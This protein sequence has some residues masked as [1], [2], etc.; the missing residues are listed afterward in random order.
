MLHGRRGPRAAAQP[1]RSLPRARVVALP[2]VPARLRLLPRRRGGGHAQR[3]GRHLGRARRV[4]VD[5]GRGLHVPYTI[6]RLRA[7][8]PSMG[9]RYMGCRYRYLLGSIFL[10]VGAWVSLQALRRHSMRGSVHPSRTATQRSVCHA[11]LSS[12]SWRCSSVPRADVEGTAIW[13]GF[14]PRGQRAGERHGTM[15]G[16]GMC[17]TDWP[18]GCPRAVRRARRRCGGAHLDGAPAGARRLDRVRC[19]RSRVVMLVE[20]R[21]PPHLRPLFPRVSSRRRAGRRQRLARVRV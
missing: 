18:A 20:R 19:C 6:E 2:A 7:P 11:V 4:A 1:R 16:G 8:S 13:S 3:G 15:V 10:L 17:V 12:L 21:P 9:C 5:V 14:P